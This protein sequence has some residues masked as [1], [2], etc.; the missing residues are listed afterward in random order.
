MERRKVMPDDT[1]LIERQTFG[2]ILREMDL[3]HSAFLVFGR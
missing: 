1:E 3:E 2:D